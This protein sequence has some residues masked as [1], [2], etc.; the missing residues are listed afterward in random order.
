MIHLIKTV[1]LI[2]IIGCQS[3]VLGQN[4][5]Y[6]E[7]PPLANESD[8][9]KNT[10]ILKVKPDF[11]A[12]CTE[13]SVDIPKLQQVFA[14]LGVITLQKKFPTLKA[15]GKQRNELGQTY[16]DLT[17]I[18]ELTYQADSKIESAVNLILT[19]GTVEYAQP[20]YIQK[21]L[22]Y[23]P[24]DPLNFNQ[25][26]LS[27]IKAYK[28]WDLYKG[29]TNTVIAI[30]DWGTDIDHPDLVNNIKYNYLDPIN[31]FDDDN[32]G[33][34]D[35]Y[36]GWDLGD[37]DNNPQGI[38]THGAFVCGM[39]SAKTD[40]NIGLSGTG[41]LCKFLPVK[42]ADSNNQ[43]TKTFEGI[44]YAVEHGCSIINCS[45]GNTFNTGPFGQDVV[46]YAAINCG[47]LVVAACG[48][49]NNMQPFYPASYNYVMSVAAS[50]STDNKWSGSSFGYFVDIAAPG[51]NV[52]STYDGGTYGGSS[53][54]SFA[55]PIVSG[56]AA[57][58]K[59]KYPNLTGLQIG[60]K[61]KVSAEIIDTGS[62]NLP[63]KDLL[64]SG[65]VNIFNAMNDS[66]CPSIVFSNHS[67]T[68]QNN[69][70]SFTKND[71]LIIKGSFINYLAPSTTGLKATLSCLSAN[72]VMIDSVTS[73]GV[74]NTLSTIN[75]NSDPFSVYLKPSI[76][77]NEELIFKLTFTDINYRAVQY[78]YFVVNINFLNIDT[79]RIA[80][81]LNST[82]MIGYNEGNCLQGLG[83]RYD[84]SETLLYSGGFIVGKSY[85]QVSDALY[86]ATGGFDHDFFSLKNLKKINSPTIAD[87]EASGIF[88]DSLAMNTKLNILVKQHAFAW[89]TAPKDK[90]VI[91]QYTIINKNSSIIN[92]VYAGLY[93]DWDIGN[94]FKNRIG[95]DATNRLGY[96]FSVEGGSYTGISLITPGPLFHYGF[97]NDGA[98]G[99]IKITSG[100]TASEKYSSLKTNRYDAGMFATGNDVSQMESSGPYTLAPNDSILLAFVVLAG[101]HIN[102]LQNSV[103]Q[104]M[105]SYFQTGITEA[106]GSSGD[107]IV[108]FQNEP[109][110]FTHKT[111]ISFYLNKEL[112]VELSYS[113]IRGNTK[114]IVYQGKL[115]K[116][117]HSFDISKTLSSGVYIYSLTSETFSIKKKMCVA[118]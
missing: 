13:T 71:T 10:V 36:R 79:N 93:L 88:N 59:S 85:T 58:L 47:A 99:S 94:S 74:I 86:G 40:N 66:V 116:G 69:D 41:F 82:G 110:P 81:T 98:N 49:S 37:N 2:L 16:A 112:N 26:H 61:L 109:N 7:L 84:N 68:D 97:D 113:D 54:T 12:Q 52:W 117:L 96:C 107:D 14:Q 108:L 43:G 19:T 29:D 115:D 45:W 27:L 114:E 76:A 60:E 80:T 67:I 22:D 46:D 56:C 51:E 24:S 6:F 25:Y 50:T 57:L 48:N 73:L 44:V 111:T 8:Y 118:Q 30:C 102:D 1:L 38:I 106:S 90:Y 77:T 4:S 5:K 87:F 105:Q 95:F 62:L 92:N 11:R 70:G 75:N 28:A 103:A 55:S 32:D 64:G 35:N 18:Y 63:Y 15:P 34:S 17:L 91:I 23:I 9:I 20:H 42:I 104:A 21:P 39:S 89:A 72:T 65:R 33:Y 78:F 101:D 83:F 31:G 53:G 100:F 3:I